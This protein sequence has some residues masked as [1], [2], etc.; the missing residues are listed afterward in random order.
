MKTLIPA[1]L[2]VLAAPAALAGG[3]TAVS[4]TGKAV[5]ERNGTR[6]P[7][8]ADAPVYSGDVVDVDDKGS[9]QLRFE[10][11]SVFVVPGV[12]RFRV[13]EFQAPVKGQGGKAI[14]TLL[15]GGMRTLTGLIKGGKGH[16]ELRTEEATITVQG[17][18]YA[19]L[20]CQGPCSSKYKPGLYVKGEAGVITVT[21]PQGELKLQP[22]QMAYVALGQAPVRAARGTTPFDDPLTAGTFAIDFQIDT[23]VHPPR[24]EG[25][26][27]A[28]PS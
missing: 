13:D 20:R 7:L 15:D 12:S 16:Y 28:S 25:E 8:E 26:S 6:M 24:I 9:A 21:N 27:S 5:V 1:L 2:L 10:D 18:A 4:V 14:Y 23:Q 3:G 17:S 22:G 11:D 19:A